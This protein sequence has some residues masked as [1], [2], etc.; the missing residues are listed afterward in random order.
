MNDDS[1]LP[2]SGPDCDQVSDRTSPSGRTPRPAAISDP[3]ASD[4][5][6]VSPDS[7]GSFQTSQPESEGW[8]G[9]LAGLSEKAMI[10]LYFFFSLACPD[11]AFCQKTERETPFELANQ[12]QADDLVLLQ[13]AILKQTGMSL[14][15][16]QQKLRQ[17]SLR[18]EEQI[19]QAENW[20]AFSYLCEHDLARQKSKHSRWAMS[21]G[22]AR[23]L[24]STVLCLILQNASIYS[25]KNH[26]KK[27]DVA[28]LLELLE[29]PKHLKGML[30]EILRP[31]HQAFQGKISP[32]S[33]LFALQIFAIVRICAGYY[34]DALAGRTGA[35]ELA[36]QQL[37]SIRHL[38]QTALEQLLPFL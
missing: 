9:Q 6:T 24:I 8:F 17:R 13:Q 1:Y 2:V 20:I 32:S 3:D 12:R 37:K 26:L 38:D 35:M 4:V 33:T 31:V 36:K 25:K 21:H 23:S 16:F 14:P 18:Y 11:M 19:E 28:F 7:A 15:E 30:K 27:K 10:R 5:L 29:D 22:K 34:L